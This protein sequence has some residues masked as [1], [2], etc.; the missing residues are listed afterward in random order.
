LTKSPKK[1]T[2][3]TA[4]KPEFRGGLPIRQLCKM[5]DDVREKLAKDISVEA[6]AQLVALSPFHFSRVFKQSTC[7]TPLQF[8]TREHITR[9]QQLI[10]EMKRSLAVEVGYTSPNHL[11]QV[12]RRVVGITPTEFARD[13]D[14][15]RHRK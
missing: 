12:F 11:A 6:L 10:L 3:G 15:N 9:A 8:S 4:K 14:R 2:D 13:F 5:E 1:Y 7:M